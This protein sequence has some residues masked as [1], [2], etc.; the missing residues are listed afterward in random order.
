MSIGSVRIA[1]AGVV[2]SRVAPIPAS[3]GFEELFNE[4]A[5]NTTRALPHPPHGEFG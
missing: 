4:I 5:G 2:R 3:L 1:A